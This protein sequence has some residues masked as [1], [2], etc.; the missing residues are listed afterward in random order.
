MASWVFCNR[1]F[2]PPRQTACFSLTNCGHVYCE[3]CLGKGKK[4][5]CVICKVPC[6]TVLL[7]KHISEFQEKHRKR[8]L[9]FYREKISKLEDSLRKSVLRIQELQ[10]MRS[11][12]QTVFST[13]RN[14]VS[15]PSAQP[16]GCPF[17]PPDSSASERVES[18]EVDLTPSPLRKPEIAAGPTRISLISPPQDGRM[19]SVSHGPQHLG[20]T[21]GHSSMPQALRIPSLQIPCKGRSHTPDPQAPGRAGSGGSPSLGGPR[22]PAP[23][24]PI[25]ISGLLQRRHAGSA[26]VR[27]FAHE[28]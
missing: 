19:G 8:L 4:D 2:Q 9:T 6:R 1:C 24:Q 7:S 16:H 25:S 17:L 20:L 15:T 14:S 22:A 12:Q 13:I 5:E 10:S 3:G 23:R 11:S 28:R 26:A 21:P 27:G 18:M